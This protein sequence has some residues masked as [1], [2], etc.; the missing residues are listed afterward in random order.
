MN[1]E[2]EIFKCKCC[3]EK[4]PNSF[5]ATN[6]VAIC[7]WCSGEEEEFAMFVEREEEGDK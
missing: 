7:R 1:Q 3:G 5:C 6:N 2:N 4:Y